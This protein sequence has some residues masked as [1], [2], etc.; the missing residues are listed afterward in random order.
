M[1]FSIPVF[2]NLFRFSSFLVVL[3]FILAA[4]P[5]ESESTAYEAPMVACKLEGA[6]IG[7]NG[8]TVV[9]NGVTIT[10]SNWI[11]K[12]GSPGEFV[13]F[14]IDKPGYTFT[15]KAGNELLSGKGTTWVNHNGTSGPNVKAISNI[16]FC[17]NDGNPNDEALCYLIADNDGFGNNSPD[18]LTKLNEVFTEQSIGLTWTDHIE[19][20]TQDTSTGI[21]YGSDDKRFGKLNTTTGAFTFIGD[22]GSGSGAQG[23]INFLDIDGLAYDP[24]TKKMYASVRRDGKDDVLIQVNIATGAAI[25]NA[26]GVGKTYI[27]V[28]KINGLQDV[29]DIAISTRNGVMYAIQNNDGNDSRLIIIDKATGA[30]TDIGDLDVPNVEGLGFHPDGRLLGV[31][32]DAH[33]SVMQI[34]IDPFTGV[35][36]PVSNLG[37]NG[38]LDYE[39]IAC[40]TET[41]NT[42]KGTVFVQPNFIDLNLVKNAS[43]TAGT[44]S[45]QIQYTVT[46]TNNN[47][48]PV[49]GP[50]APAG[51][52]QAGITVNLYR[53][54]NV[55]GVYDGNDV[56]VASTV[57]GVG[58]A[59]T[60][61]ISANG[62]FIVTVDL[63]TVPN[64]AYLPADNQEAV[65]FIGFGETL[66]GKDFRFYTFT[67]ATGITVSDVFPANATF[68]SASATVGSYNSGTKIWTLGTLAPGASATLTINATTTFSGQLI[69]CAEVKT[70]SPTDIDSTPGNGTGNAEDDKDCEPTNHVRPEVDLKL[71]KS[72]DKSSAELGETIVYT[73]TLTNESAGTAGNVVVKDVLPFGV[74]FVSSSPAAVYSAIDHSVTWTV[75]S[76]AGG[77]VQVLNITV[78]FD[79]FSGIMPTTNWLADGEYVLRNHP[80]VGDPTPPPFFGLRLDKLFGGKTPITFDFNHAQS[81]MRMRLENGGATVVIYGTTWGGQDTGASFAFA[82]LWD[83]YFKY[84]NKASVVAGDDDIEVKGANVELSSGTISPNY[85]TTDFTN[86]QVFNLGDKADGGYSFRLGNE[87]NDL[88][89]RGHNGISGWG[90]ITHNGDG[91]MS[92]KSASD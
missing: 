76:I 68:A 31:N 46:V 83:V 6:A 60:F 2:G 7:V 53:D 10:F 65:Q 17:M 67:N 62:N 82:G 44:S 32:G 74:S 25:P 42:I 20:L 77:A 58:G 56:F 11:P 41:D 55:I 27:V 72:A 39:G 86:G 91:V 81:D 57:T 4:I 5:A 85:T 45:D 16:N 24:F 73:L 26:F 35:T 51:T 18:G 40:L 54:N 14:T 79:G 70:A 38:W 71:E 59:Y 1:R 69:N 43:V 50:N 84:N 21:V 87:N 37:I 48:N 3:A 23:N 15:V 47:T 78:K 75:A 92:Y 34:P 13:G 63:T 22:F 33:R 61:P 66:V 9:V 29:D 49:A 88:G 36:I 90:W 64:L 8:S 52:G 89:H 19:A 30:T 28:Q 12:V 80:V